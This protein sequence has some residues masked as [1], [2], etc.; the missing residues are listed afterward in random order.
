MSEHNKILGISYTQHMF[1]KQGP[2]FT[3]VHTILW[4][5]SSS[6]SEKKLSI[7]MNFCSYLSGSFQNF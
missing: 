4:E 3:V 1:L 5:A 6:D 2:F 7:G